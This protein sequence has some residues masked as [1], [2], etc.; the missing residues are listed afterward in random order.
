MDGLVG[1]LLSTAPIVRGKFN[2]DHH[3][4]LQRPSPLTL[5][6][7]AEA[8][9]QRLDT[10]TAQA[11]ARQ[12]AQRPTTNAPASPAFSASVPPAAGASARRR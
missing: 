1:Q 7:V 5:E 9:F 4:A 11:R 12:R 10:F 3:G 6:Q 8:H 2:L